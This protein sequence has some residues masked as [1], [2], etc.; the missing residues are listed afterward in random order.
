M[1]APKRTPF[2]RE[3]D[4]AELASRYL[5]G[6]I[7]ANIAGGMGVT[8]QQL[9]YDL[10][11]LRKRWQKSALADI[12]EAIHQI[13]DATDPDLTRFQQRGGK[14]LMY[15]GW[16]DP[17][18]NPLMGVEYYEKVSE[19][20][21]AGTPGFFRLFMAPGMFH[22]GGG[23]GPSVIDAFTPLTDWV[24]RGVAPD[25]IQA[26]RMVS[27]KAVRTRP[28]CAYPEVAKYQGSGS[29]DEAASFTC[30]KP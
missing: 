10:A 12:N 20:M 8:H 13:L 21:G 24:E 11:I 29:V 15:F 7:L 5:H 3:K 28:L 27:G 18:L 9:S 25:A 14:I 30:V 1:A 6:E 16:A 26:S 2:Q 22:C 19:R 23:V 4:L 17:A